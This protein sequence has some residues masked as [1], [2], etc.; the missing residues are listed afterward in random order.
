MGA[1]GIEQITLLI[2]P[3]DLSRSP[4]KKYCVFLEFSTCVKVKVAV[5]GR[6][7][8]VQKRLTC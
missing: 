1:H 4:Y 6:E 2:V 3:S 7:K 8:K 5:L